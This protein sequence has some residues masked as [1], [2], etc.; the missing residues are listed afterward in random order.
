MPKTKGFT[1]KE[2]QALAEWLRSLDVKAP[3]KPKQQ[4]RKAS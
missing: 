4:A 1:A 3:R 2:Q